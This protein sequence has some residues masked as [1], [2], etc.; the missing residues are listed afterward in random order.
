M[1]SLTSAVAILL[2]TRSVSLA[3]ASIV[4]I[5]LAARALQFLRVPTA[6]ARTIRRR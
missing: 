1:L 2:S 4:V 6:R 3:V 5:R